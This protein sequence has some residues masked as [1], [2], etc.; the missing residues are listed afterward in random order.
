MFIR[1]RAYYFVIG[2]FCIVNQFVWSQDQRV[3]DSLTIIYQ[4]DKLEKVEKLEL[5]KD[6]S[7]NE[8]NDI[9]LALKYADEL[10]VLSKLA[11]ENYYLF[12]GYYNKGNKVKSLGE[13]EKALANFFYQLKSL[14][15][16]IP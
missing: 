8:L 15:R 2:L 6:L 1:K 10:I 3:A 14:L 9:E 5:L 12:S 11:K 13:L 7:F 4:T 16:K